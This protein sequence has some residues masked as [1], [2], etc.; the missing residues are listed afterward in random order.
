M[1][2]VYAEATST[3]PEAP[4]LFELP[5]PIQAS[6]EE[7]SPDGENLGTLLGNIPT[8]PEEGAPTIVP[9]GPTATDAN[10]AGRHRKRTADEA[11]IAE[12]DPERISSRRSSLLD[13]LHAE[14]RTTFERARPQ[15]GSDAAASSS[16][17]FAIREA[18]VA[19]MSTRGY[20]SSVSSQKQDEPSSSGVLNYRNASPELK[21]KIDESRLSEWTKYQNFSASIPIKGK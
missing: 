14:I 15:E 10:R 20:A 13:D 19:C 11:N 8:I 2:D 4:E 6:D 17:Q 1:G 12:P 18:F 16:G 21:S 9:K 3:L 7:I 5:V